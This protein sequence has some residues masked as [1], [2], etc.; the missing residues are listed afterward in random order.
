MPET[1]EKTIF[2]CFPENRWEALNQ[3]FTLL[4]FSKL[5]LSA[6]VKLLHSADSGFLGYKIGDVYIELCLTSGE[7]IAESEPDT[8][9]LKLRKSKG[10]TDFIAEYT[11]E[12]SELT[13]HLT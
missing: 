10:K 4:G 9:C 7:I 8:L 1:V 6:L 11:F 2:D 3:Y 12:I 5:E 13:T